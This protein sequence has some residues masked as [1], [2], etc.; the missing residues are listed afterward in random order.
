MK[1]PVRMY[2]LCIQNRCRSQIAEAFAKHY[3]GDNVTV[4]S[5]GL[6]AST[7]HP[8][9]IEVMKEV[10]ID[11]SANK[12]KSIDMQTFMSADVVVKLCEQ[13]NEKCPV[14]P[15]GIKNEQWDIPDPLKPEGQLD[16]VRQA[17]DAIRER[18]LGLLK[19]YQIP[20]NE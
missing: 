18:V 16:D 2:F 10:G 8:H 9:T 4:E 7:I 5:A 13:V 15:F 19:E 3:G 17:R 6:D 20:I 14:V 11:I 1:K 12:S